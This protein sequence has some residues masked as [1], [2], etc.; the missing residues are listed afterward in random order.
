MLDF[1]FD[2]I[3][4]ILAL[5]WKDKKNVKV[6]SNHKATEP[7]QSVTWWSR[8]R[9]EKVKVYQT[10]CIATYKKWMGGVDRM[11]W[12]INKYRIRIR[13]KKRHFPQISLI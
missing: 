12:S 6:L 3:N 11:D 8:E 7:M 2:E 5:T 4:S 10:K 9:K 13:G 1:R